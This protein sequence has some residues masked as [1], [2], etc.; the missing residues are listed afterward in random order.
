MTQGEHPALRPAAGSAGGAPVEVLACT[1]GGTDA[2]APILHALPLGFRSATV[3]ARHEQPGHHSVLVD[4]VARR[5]ALAVREARPGSRLRPGAVLV[6]RPGYHALV[7]VGERI[8]LVRRDGPPPYRP[9]ADL[10][11]VS[12]ALTAPRRTIAVILSGLGRD[13]ATGAAALHDLGGRVIAADAASSRFADLPTAVIRQG[14][15]VEG[16]LPVDRVAERLERWVSAPVPSSAPVCRLGSA[17][18]R[19]ASAVPKSAPTRSVEG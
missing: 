19:G 14:D 7:T 12:L 16:V 5:C 4:V 2:L 17:L 9:S 13:G 15:V 11:P 10:L 1:A 8:A 18:H 3:V 6:V